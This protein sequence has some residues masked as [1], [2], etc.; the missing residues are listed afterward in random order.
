MNIYIVEDDAAIRDM[1]AYALQSKGYDVRALSC[2][3]ELYVACE[4]TVPDLLIL[5][6]ML[7]GEDGLSILSTVRRSRKT[8]DIPVMMVT[9]K[10]SELDRVKG[11]DS[12]AD[13]YLVKPFG[14][15][16]LVSR[17]K[18]LLRR[19]TPHTTG[20][21]LCIGQVRINDD[22]HEVYV[23]DR[24][25]VLTHKEYDLLKML[26]QNCDRVISR[27][28]LL[29]NVWGYEY[30][31]ETRTVDVHVKTLRQKLSDA[32]EHIETVRGVGYKFIS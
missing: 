14:V 18:A 12:G 3:E 9:A 23:Q 30:G 32:A 7:P 16:E 2:A 25:C 19:R 26:M 28:T 10:G 8:A 6:I 20:L 11:L 5:D 31:G 29:N 17:V 15:M 27:E 13:D 22:A 1:E 21:S 24:L 4:E